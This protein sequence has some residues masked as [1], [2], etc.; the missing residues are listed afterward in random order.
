MFSGV[1]LTKGSIAIRQQVI[2]GFFFFFLFIH[3]R[4]TDEVL[5]FLIRGWKP[6]RGAVQGVACRDLAPAWCLA[7][8]HLW[9]RE[10]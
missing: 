10:R 5:G 2:D 9:A 1:F 6:Q 7:Q 4:M 8:E 3:P